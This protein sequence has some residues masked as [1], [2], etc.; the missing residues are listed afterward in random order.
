MSLLPRVSDATGSLQ[1]THV[2]GGSIN[3]KDFD[4]DVSIGHWLLFDDPTQPGILA[5]GTQPNPTQPRHK[6]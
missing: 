6:I 5:I 3:K 2:K 1:F 4:R